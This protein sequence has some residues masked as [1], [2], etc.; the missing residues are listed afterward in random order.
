MLSQVKQTAKD[1]DHCCPTN[2]CV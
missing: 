2:F 1:K